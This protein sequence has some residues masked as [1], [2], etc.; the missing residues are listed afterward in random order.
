MK[1]RATIHVTGVVQGVGFRPFV[2]RLAESLSLVGYVLNLG[3]AGVEI[4]VEGEEKDIHSLV[5]TM[6]SNPPSISRINTLDIVWQDAEESFKSFE[7]TRSSTSRNDEAIPVLP[8]DIAICKDCINDLENHSSRWYLYPFTSCASCGP[9]F[10]TITDLPYDRPNTTMIDFPLC[11][12]CN[13]G[14]TNPLDRRYHAQTTACHNCGPLYHLLDRQGIKISDRDSIEEAAKLIDEDAI[15]AIQGISGTHIATKTSN[16]TPIKN[17][18]TRKRRS[19]QPFAIMVRDLETL[20]GIALTTGIMEKLLTSW[21]RPIVLVPKVSEDSD[22]SQVIPRTSLDQIAP[23]LDTVGVMLP[24]AP[25]HHLLFKYTNE[26]ALVLTSANPTG[27]P[28]YIDTGIIIGEL[29][30]IV[31]YFLI[32][33]RRIHQRAD[34]S[35]VK[36]LKNDN[37][38][39]IRRAR[40]YVPEPIAFNGSWKSKKILGVGPEEKATGSLLKSGQIYLTQYIGDT[41]Q[42]DNIEFLSDAINHMQNLLG[43]SKLDAIAC[44]LHPEFLST[45][46]AEKVAVE[47]DAP[48]FR[49]Q[50]HHAHLSTIMIDGLLPFNNRIVCITAD[51]FGYG[52]DGT[53]WGGDILV[54]DL[55]QSERRGGL[56]AQEYTGGDL[57][58][59]YAARSLIGIVGEELERDEIISMLSSAKISQD[60]LITESS[61]EILVKASQQRI[62]TITSTSAGRFLDAVAVTLGICSE[63][64]YDAECPMKLEAISQRTDIKIK[65]H[66][67]QSKYGTVLDTTQS[68]LQIIDL[69]KKGTKRSELAF[70]AQQHLGRSLAEI[71]CDIAE[72]EG[73][74]HIGFSGGVALNRIITESI[75]KE[76]HERKFVP[77]FHTLIPPGDGGVSA[78]QVASAAARLMD[79]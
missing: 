15:I 58:A 2:Y 19:Q 30:N 27:M 10:S 28:M 21:R 48:L 67:V 12:T 65:P 1:R 77:I 66:F 20:R 32:H 72:S 76:V 57:S 73:I 16:A 3:D 8:P 5:N 7:I 71:A 41:N 50:H 62:N 55:R 33:N 44:D 39:F 4:V 34:D 6:K 74:M 9:R 75:D 29:G 43:I 70:A 22:I 26:P 60:T 56:K 59:I 68:L 35:V 49:V 37:P 52:T 38:V 25:V 42:V 45:E 64:S 61:L 53:A 69:L 54:G 11:N 51:G 47:Q 46:L 63:N 31:D 36:L 14:Y 24:Y 23:G 18:R 17:L 40:G 13:I 78:G 79:Y